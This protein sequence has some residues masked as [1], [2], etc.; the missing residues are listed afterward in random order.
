MKLSVRFFI[1]LGLI[2]SV[3]VF[4]GLSLMLYFQPRDF[5][6]QRLVWALI[7]LGLSLLSMGVLA[8]ELLK[9]RPTATPS[10]FSP[11]RIFLLVYLVTPVVLVFPLWVVTLGLGIAAP[12]LSNINRQQ[13]FSLPAP[14]VWLIQGGILFLL[15]LP[16]IIPLRQWKFP[17]QKPFL[18]LGVSLILGW[19]LALISL[20]G[21]H[22]EVRLFG[23]DPVVLF[24]INRTSHW[25]AGILMIFILPV[26]EQLFFRKFLF[27]ALSERFSSQKAVW[28]S[29]F[30]F[31]VVQGRPLLF[32]PALI[33]S[34]VLQWWTDTSGDLRTAILT[35]AIANAFILAMNW[36]LVL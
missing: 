36:T 4:A 32:L 17:F 8:V 33:F 21:Y 28:L 23:I 5:V 20:Y 34:L 2:L 35:H 7:G 31:A 18:Y 12:S 24:P 25:L 14:W 30:L 11:W 26:S 13:V 22:L 1:L 3:F 6:S 29:A 9:R 16:K 10:L 27:Q 19:M 15:L